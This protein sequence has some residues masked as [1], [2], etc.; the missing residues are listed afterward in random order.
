MQPPLATADYWEAEGIDI[1]TNP[2][3]S[4]D[5]SGIEAVVRDRG[6]AS[7]VVLA[8]SGSSGTPKWIVLEKR[9]LL[10]SAAAVNEHCSLVTDDSWLGGLSTFHVG[11]LGIYARAYLAGSTVVPMDWRSWSR[12]GSVLIQAIDASDSRVTSLTP[13]HLHDLVAAR[14]RCPESLRGVFI[15]GGATD[16]DLA[17][18]ARDLGWPLWTTYGMTEAS[19]QIA[20]SLTGALDTLP[21]LPHWQTQID[22]LG[23]LQIRGEALMAGYLTREAETWKWHDAIDDSGYYTTSDLAQISSSPPASTLQ[24]LGRAD[25]QLKILGELVAIEKVETALRACLGF[26]IAIIAMPEP[27]RGATLHAFVESP[28]PIAQSILEEWNLAQPP[29]EQI[30]SLESMTHLPRTDLGK[31]DRQALQATLHRP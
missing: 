24:I 9:S 11:G 29:F 15:G 13:I 14:V 16:P 3:R 19:S 30:A 27:R 1:R 31:I 25:H 26:P 17:D 18:Q 2:A 28:A 10:C 20:T 12:D 23:R 8:T 5:T 21:I 22:D 6:I 4:D 7:A